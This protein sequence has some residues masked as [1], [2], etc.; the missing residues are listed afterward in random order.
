VTKKDGEL[1]YSG[2]IIF[3]SKMLSIVTGLIFQL[4]I[5]RATSLPGHELE[6]DLWFNINDILMYFTLLAGVL[7]FWIMRFAARDKEG[8]TKTG[9]LANLTI[10]I[11]ATLIYLPLIPTITALLNIGEKY[12][13][14]YVILSIQIIE[15]HLLS[16]LEAYLHAKIPQKIG[17]GLL[18]QQFF[19]VIL[20]YILIIQIQ[21]PLVGAI[22][23][24]VLALCIQAIYYSRLL[25]GE[26][27]KKVRWRYVKEWIKG[28]ILNVYHVAGNQIAAYVLIMLFAFGGEGARGRYGAANQIASVITYSYFLAYALYPK[29]LADRKRGDVVL[30]LRMVLMFAIPMTVGAM[31]LSDSYIIIM[32]GT[33]YRDAAFVLIVLA[34]N[35]F[36]LVISGFL[37]SVLFG[38]ERVDEFASISFK[39]LIKS[40]LIIPFSLPYIHSIITLPTAFYFLN[41]FTKNQPFQSAFYVSLINAVARLVGFL[42]L[43]STVK[44]VVKIDVPWGNIKKYLLA[45]AVMMFVLLL[46]P[47]PT[48]ITVTLLATVMGAIIYLSVLTAIDKETRALLFWMWREMKHKFLSFE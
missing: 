36:L 6:Y 32:K 14:L 27:N 24:S 26:W 19:K 8:T 23:A 43:Y 22:T 47:H 41:T 3:A 18:I 46:V 4:M 44:K 10:A 5:A 7:P 33:M 34:I 21:Q 25:D 39:A 37:N 9:I 30:S 31:V 45:S 16:V 13:F 35:A 2:L 11:I 20:G 15:I 28:S 1:Y 48:K 17:Y 29:L 42:V 38:F 12:V 40:R